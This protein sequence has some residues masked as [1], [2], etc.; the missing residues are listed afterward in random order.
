MDPHNRRHL[1][2]HTIPSLR[3]YRASLGS[4]P[5]LLKPYL[6]PYRSRASLC[7][8]YCTI[9]ILGIIIKFDFYEHRKKHRNHH[10]HH[11]VKSRAGLAR[12]GGTA[13]IHEC[14]QQSQPTETHPEKPEKES[15]TRTPLVSFLQILH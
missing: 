2:I 14:I 13:I 1:L 3:D 15:G 12:R 8:C 6:F 10:R 9:I 11:I 7:Y 4:T 5:P